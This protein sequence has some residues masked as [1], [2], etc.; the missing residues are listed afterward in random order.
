MSKDKQGK[1]LQGI[2]DNVMIEINTLWRKKTLS[3]LFYA[4]FRKRGLLEK[5]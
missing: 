4:F 3:K 1:G 5:K 2:G